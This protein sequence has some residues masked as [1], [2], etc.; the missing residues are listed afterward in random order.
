MMPLLDDTPADL[1]IL[2]TTPNGDPDGRELGNHMV[3]LVKKAQ[4]SV[5][6]KA[7]FQRKA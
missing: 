5:S 6:A 3:N 7:T 2:H 4:G 1:R